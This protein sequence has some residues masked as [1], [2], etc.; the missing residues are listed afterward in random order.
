M[1]R[2]CF[3]EWCRKTSY[4]NPDRKLCRFPKNTKT[5]L[6]D[7]HFPAK[8]FG[9]K[10]LKESSYE[11]IKTILRDKGISVPTEPLAEKV[12]KNKRKFSRKCIIPH[13]Q[14]SD[15]STIP[16]LKF[17]IFPKKDNELYDVWV[18]KCNLSKEESAKVYKY[19]CEKH[20]LN[21]TDPVPNC[22]LTATGN[23]K[24]KYQLSKF[25]QEMGETTDGPKPTDKYRDNSEV[26]AFHYHICHCSEFIEHFCS[27]RTTTI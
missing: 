26:K 1:P 11:K 25:I 2:Y 5:F 12:R 13:C 14:L 10:K 22:N 17:V 3:I 7:Q 9:K 19:V 24:R 18:A 4:K 23:V 21:K 15:T 8:F 6:C 16:P 20:F 27:L